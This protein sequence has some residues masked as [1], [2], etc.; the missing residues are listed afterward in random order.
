MVSPTA[1]TD[2]SS[3]RPSRRRCSLDLARRVRP[4]GSIAF[5]RQIPSRVGRRT[6]KGDLR[7]HTRG[8]GSSRPPARSALGRRLDAEVCGP[9]VRCS[10]AGEGLDGRLP[11]ADRSALN[12]S[13]VLESKGTR[14]PAGVH[15]AREKRAV[16]HPETDE[17]HITV[18]VRQRVSVGRPRRAP[19]LERARATLTT[20]LSEDGG[21]NDD[22]QGFGSSRL[23][24]RE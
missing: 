1:A 15:S 22:S 10:P 13:R 24:Y 17:R 11:A 18:R 19:A 16:D 20:F 9:R 6:C 5:W 7:R 23:F 2:C 14:P 12:A 21:A 3:S 4:A 8:W